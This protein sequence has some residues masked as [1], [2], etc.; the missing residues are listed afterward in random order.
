MKAMKTKYKY[1]IGIDPDIHKSGVAISKEGKLIELT[2]LRFFDLYRKLSCWT[3]E[4]PFVRIEAGWLNEK[5]N[6]SK[7][8]RTQNK[9]A[10]E[11]IAKNVGENAQAG[12]KI[13]E[14]MDDLNIAY[15]L[16]RPV[17]AKTKPEYFKV[18]TGREVKNQDVIDAAML[19]LGL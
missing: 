8:N 15:E 3:E 16:V 9:S 14:M 4:S 5:S 19:V 7:A 17:K 18:L 11:R 13:A 1:Y 2:T 12:K 6:F 10:G